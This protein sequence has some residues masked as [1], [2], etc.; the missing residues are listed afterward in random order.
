MVKRSMD[1]KLR[2]RNFDARHGKIGTEAVIKNRKG[3]SGV[4][5]GKGTCFQWKEKGK[6]SEGNQC[7]FRHEINDSAQQKPN[8]NAATPSE[9]SMTRGRSV[10]L[11]RSIKGKSNPG[12]ILRQPCRYYLKCNCTRS[13]CEYWHP[14]QCQFLKN[15]SGC[16]GGDKCLFPHHKVDEQ[17]NKKPKKSDHSQR[18]ASDDK[19]AAAIVKIVSQMGCVSQDDSR[20]RK[21]HRLETYKSKNTHHQSPYAMKFEDRS[22]E[23][24]ERQQ[25]CARS[26][27]WNLAKH[28]YKF[29]KRQR[30]IPLARRRMGTPGCGN[31]RAGGK[32]V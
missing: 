13:L 10:S 16:K 29:H 28:I 3:L 31:R 19:N 30:Y 17:P 18:G 22:H 8:P 26:N 11:K 15:E 4:G 23:E 25:R 5:G 32:R 20:K 14:L 6:C 12:V 7:S 1:Q 27:A 9:P 24:T 2:L 21:D